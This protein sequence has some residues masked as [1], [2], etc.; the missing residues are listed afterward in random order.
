MSP[1]AQVIVSTHFDD[2]ALSLAHVLQDAGAL[3]TVVTVCGGAP[4]DDVPVSAWDAGCGFASGAQA[5]L[6]RAGEDAAACAVTGAH[7]LPLDHPDSPYAPL[8][9]APGLRAEIEPLLPAGCTLWLPA[10]IGDPA[11]ADHVHVH[12]ALMPLAARVRVRVYADLPYA[13]ALGMQAGHEVRLTDEAFERKLTAVRCHG[14]QLSSLE[15]AWPD[16]LARGG[17]LACERHR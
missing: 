7:P 16:L 10:G 13:G 9:D 6:A 14:S 15:R 8:P 17:P 4:R 5:A 2:A 11:N 3:A 12:D 1:P